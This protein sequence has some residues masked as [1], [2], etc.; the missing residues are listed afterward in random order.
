[1]HGSQYRRGQTCHFLLLHSAHAS[2][3]STRHS[4]TTQRSLESRHFQQGS[5]ENLV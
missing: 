4:I 1:M 3:P 2:E 5:L